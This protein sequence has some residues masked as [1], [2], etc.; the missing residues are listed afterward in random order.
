MPHEQRLRGKTSRD[1]RRGSFWFN[2][3]DSLLPLIHAGARLAAMRNAKL[4]QGLQERRHIK[5]GW[6]VGDNRDGAGILLHAASYGEYEALRPL[7]EKLTDAGLRV[8]VSY[9]SPSAQKAVASTPHLWA[10]GYLPI[11]YLDRQLA[12]LGQLNPKAVLITKHDI[13]PNLLR[14]ARILDIPTGLINGSFHARSHRSDLGARSF[15]RAVL[16]N[17]DFI[18]TVSDADTERVEPLL[19]SHTELKAVGDTRFDRVKQRALAGKER[20]AN[21]KHALGSHPV[22]I[23]GS[24]W[25][26][27]LEIVWAVFKELIK[28]NSNLKLII[29]PHELNNGMLSQIDHLAV[30]D[31]LP[32]MLYSHWQG[33]S[34]DKP[35]IVVDVMGVLAEIYTVGWAALVGGGFGAGVHSVIEPAAHGLPVAFGPRHQVS[36]EAGL[37]LQA[38][39][40]YE[41]KTNLELYKLWNNWL[42]NNHTYHQASSAASEVVRSREGATELV[43]Q[44]IM[45]LL[46]N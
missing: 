11:D 36:H 14:A 41:I 18:W 39:G 31:N 7:I 8:A 20:F 29:A 12:L 44:K 33:E 22:I 27:E 1:A 34:I 6:T 38:G 30:K 16:S 28:K 10:W 26:K 43:F 25:P 32:L 19:N 23:A 42:E 21:L 4:R 9:F 35:V 15:N 40:G 13:W 2:L 17:F 3:Y 45:N 5:G 46:N 37:L 24:A